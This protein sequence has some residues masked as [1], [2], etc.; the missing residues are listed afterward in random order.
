MNFCSFF[1]VR[2]CIQNPSSSVTIFL[3]RHQAV[4]TKTPNNRHAFPS[5]DTIVRPI[6]CAPALLTAGAKWIW[7]F[8]V[9]I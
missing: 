3:S 1:P 4:K 8:S 7:P 2:F 6:G 5:V 9:V